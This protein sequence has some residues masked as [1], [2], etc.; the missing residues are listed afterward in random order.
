MTLGWGLSDIPGWIESELNY[1]NIMKAIPTMIAQMS[2]L[3]RTFNIDALIVTEGANILA[4]IERYTTVVTREASVNN[5][6][7]MDVI[8]T[9]QAIQRD[10]KEVPSLVRLSR[11]D[12]SG[13]AGIPEELILSIE[14]GSFSSGDTTE[15]ALEKQWESTK[16]IHKQCADQLK[17]L[18]MLEIINALGTDNDVIE[19][20]PY[21][22]L[23]FDNP[24]V[25]NAEIRSKIASNLGKS[26]LDI[27]AGGTPIDAAMQ[28]MSSYA[29]YEFAVR[30]NLI[31]DLKER[32]KVLDERAEEKHRLEME[33]L[34][35]EIDSVKRGADVSFGKNK[36]DKGYTKL[37]QM[38]HEKSR[39]TN[40]RNE[41]LAKA[42]NKKII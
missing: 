34:E 18:V 17:P 10:F 26:L 29:D 13:K 15:G 2:I 22:V 38:K 16:Y 42:E 41:A 19:A 35:A 7:S 24:I 32:Q 3:V 37:E 20:L 11:Q 30:D 12:F 27:V 33:K 5:P 6:I 14:R 25:A 4:E 31:E 1:E 21:T 8:G 40:K 39:G 9:L 28:I 36:G 23:D